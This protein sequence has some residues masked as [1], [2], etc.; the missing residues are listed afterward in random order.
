MVM[1]T[2]Q[3]SDKLRKK[4]KRICGLEDKTYEEVIDERVK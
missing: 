2:I 1:T 3:I 4:L